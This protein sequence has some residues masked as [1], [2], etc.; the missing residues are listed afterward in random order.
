L[1]AIGQSLPGRVTI[2]DR[3]SRLLDVEDVP[4]LHFATNAV[5]DSKDPNRSHIMFSS[6]DYL[7][8]GEIQDLPL[9]RTD[10]VTLSACDTGPCTPLSTAFL[11]AGARSTVTT[12]W[13]V[14]DGPTADFMA[15]FYAGLAKGESKAAAL[16]NT[17]L[18][19]IHSGTTLADPRFWAAFVLYGNG[20]APIRPV[21]SWLWLLV[22]A[23]IGLAAIMLKKSALK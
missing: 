15:R 12:L 17:K 2:H 1:K 7:F 6:V 9:S 16:R 19:F 5:A 18:S 23:G 4:L 14:P 13:R 11:A 8:R 10:L 22:P 20:Q 21:L 3:K